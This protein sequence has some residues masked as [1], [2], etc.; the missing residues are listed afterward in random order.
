MPGSWFFST[1]RPT[2]ASSRTSRPRSRHC[3]IHGYR[4][5]VISNWDSNLPEMCRAWGIAPFFDFILASWGVGYA[6]PNPRI[7][8][9]AVHRAGRGRRQHAPRG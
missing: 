9:E 7:F 6:K 3:A 8:Q 1:T 5:G 2:T 4:L